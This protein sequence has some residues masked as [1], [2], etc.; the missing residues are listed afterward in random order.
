MTAISKLDAA[1]RLII[2]SIEMQMR[3]FDRL[4]AHVVAASAFNL[5]RE[6]MLVG[7]ERFALRLLAEGIFHSAVAINEGHKVTLTGNDAVK[8]TIIKVADAIRVGE[9]AEPEQ[10]NI[11]ITEDQEAGLLKFI[12]QPYN[13]LKHAK[14]DQDVM[15]DESSVDPKAATMLAMTAMGWLSP[16]REFPDHIEPYLVENGLR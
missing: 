9:I 16:G 15:L 4:A 2:S 13:F 11:L 5:L 10:I 7:G 1:H 8:E 6:L 14:N 3:D 12:R